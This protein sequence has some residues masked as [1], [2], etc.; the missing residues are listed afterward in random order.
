MTA[1]F[2]SV[3]FHLLMMNF[4]VYNIPEGMQASVA[5]NK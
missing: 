2:D 4:V 5:S 3:T 1:G